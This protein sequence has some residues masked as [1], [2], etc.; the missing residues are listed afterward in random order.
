MRAIS[1][2]ESVKHLSASASCKVFVKK[3]AKAASSKVR[4]I[5]SKLNLT[6]LSMPAKIRS[7][8][9]KSYNVFRRLLCT[10]EAKKGA[11]DASV[12]MPVGTINPA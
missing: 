2:D 11:E 5:V 8:F 10:S 7:L 12:A 6:R 9:S 4:P 1:S 3:N